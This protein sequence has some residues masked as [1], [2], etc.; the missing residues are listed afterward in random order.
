MCRNSVKVVVFLRWNSAESEPKDDPTNFTTWV[1]HGDW[2]EIITNKTK[3]KELFVRDSKSRIWFCHRQHLCSVISIQK[4]FLADVL[5]SARLL[6]SRNHQ[7][8]RANENDPIS[9]DEPSTCEKQMSL[10]WLVES[11]YIEELFDRRRHIA[12]LILRR[13]ELAQW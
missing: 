9:G 11:F 12:L 3:T 10:S 1:T 13:G 6:Q 8:C 4:I 2:I 7:A 5:E